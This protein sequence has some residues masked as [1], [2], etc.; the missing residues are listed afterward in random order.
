ME[1]LNFQIIICA[2]F[3]MLKYLSENDMIE[4]SKKA[5]GDC[6]KDN[7]CTDI[8]FNY[9]NIYISK[10]IE[11]IVAITG[12]YNLLKKEFKNNR[13]WFLA[14]AGSALHAYC[15]GEDNIL[16]K[17]LSDAEEKVNKGE[18]TEGKYINYCNNLKEF[19]DTFTL[20]NTLCEVEGNVIPYPVE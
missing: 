2:V 5:W 15:K 14:V 19:M 9:Y 3:P 17:R 8:L 4:E 10:E 12:M 11:P 7:L 1:E 6:E 18:M 13:A 16:S 20:I